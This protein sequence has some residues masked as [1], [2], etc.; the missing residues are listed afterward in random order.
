MK[1]DNENLMDR[2][3]NEREGSELSK[4][5]KRTVKMNYPDQENHVFGSFPPKHK[6]LI[7]YYQGKRLEAK[8]FC[9]IHPKILHIGYNVS[10]SMF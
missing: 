8:Q 5:R 9:M 6:S 2:K 7:P 10:N 4:S 3:S 1:N